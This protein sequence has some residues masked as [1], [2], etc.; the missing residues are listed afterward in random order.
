MNYI[1]TYDKFI[2]YFKS[3]TPLERFT[4]RNISSGRILNG[5]LYTEKH[6]ILPTS[7][8][9]SDLSENIVV[10]LPEEHLFIHKL[11]YKA[12]KHREDM[13][14]VRFILN[15]LNNKTQGNFSNLRLHLTKSI[16]KG[17]AFIKQESYE[18]R[19]KYGWHTEEG[20]KNI[21]EARK[22]TFPM[23]DIIT[24]EIVGSFSKDH[25]NYLSGEWVHHSKGKVPVFD[26]VTGE[27]LYIDS[28]IYQSNK[29]RYIR[30][31]SDNSGR[32]NSRYIDISD[33]QIVEMHSEI[34]LIFGYIV[35]KPILAEYALNMYNLKIPSSFSSCRF[36]DK[37]LFELT[38]EKT[39]LK[40]KY[41]KGIL[42]KEQKEKLKEIYDKN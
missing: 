16:L 30:R 11:R 41:I 19:T 24:G 2:R 42:Y 37:S 17:Y 40:Y 3:T 33:E 13:L 32:N 10:L 27:N 9:G 5:I 12:F 25:I 6:H 39:N 28:E 15:G 20:I 29:D 22:G 38:E 14:A 34:S 31:G 23:K 7:L 21:S 4:I 26:N 18:F 8:G 35:S 36:K 1:K